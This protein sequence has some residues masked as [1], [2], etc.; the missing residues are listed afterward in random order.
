VGPGAGEP[1]EGHADGVTAVAGGVVGG[2]PVAVSG[3][4]DGAVRVSD[5]ATG[6]QTGAER[7]FPRAVVAVAM[8]PDGRAVAA[9]ADGL[10][11]LAPR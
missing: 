5:L 6:E 8:T 10:A 3:G 9:S 2:R 11:V 1:F 7:V 4:G